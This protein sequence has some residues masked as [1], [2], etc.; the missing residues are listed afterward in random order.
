M[1]LVSNAARAACDRSQN[2]KRYGN[3]LIF[4]FTKHTAINLIQV[5]NSPALNNVQDEP[6]S[7]GDIGKG[8]Q[9]DGTNDMKSDTDHP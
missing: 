2:L 3:K 7:A 4:D 9:F 1:C 5:A 6:V 8:M